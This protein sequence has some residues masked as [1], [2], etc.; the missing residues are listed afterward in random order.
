MEG[1]RSQEL[2]VPIGQWDSCGQHIVVNPAHASVCSLVDAV[3]ELTVLCLVHFKSVVHWLL[4]VLIGQHGLLDSKFGHVGDKDLL[5]DAHISAKVELKLVE[6]DVVLLTS[7]PDAELQERLKLHIIICEAECD[8][9][10]AQLKLNLQLL[11]ITVLG[12]NLGQSFLE[13][14]CIDLDSVRVHVLNHPLRV[15]VVIEPILAFQGLHEAVGDAIGHHE[16]HILVL[17][18]VLEVVVVLVGR[19]QASMTLRSELKEERE[20]ELM[21]VD[22]RISRQSPVQREVALLAQ[23]VVAKRE[24]LHLIV[25]SIL[26]DVIQVVVDEVCTEH[27]IGALQDVLAKVE[28]LSVD[29]LEDRVLMVQVRLLD[30]YFQVVQM[31]EDVTVVRRVK[32]ARH[33]GSQVSEL[34]LHGADIVDGDWPIK[35]VVKGS[36]PVLN[37]W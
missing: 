22:L 25:Q 24:I 10:L 32:L 18:I 19:H 2:E 23:L 7:N 29:K 26:R 16:L 34:H 27:V 33:D 9:G 3:P 1:E 17:V 11:V 36:G 30:V 8:A 13:K 4:S 12:G 14:S 5:I 31:R 15:D 6:E 37:D 35:G 20:V 21:V 28:E